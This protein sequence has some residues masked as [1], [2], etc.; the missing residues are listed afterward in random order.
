MKVNKK[1]IRRF[2][3][4][5]D[6]RPLLV[7]GFVLLANLLYVTNFFN[8][9]PM[10]LRSGLIN[11]LK[12]GISQGQYTIDPSDGFYAQALGHRAAVDA[13]RGNVP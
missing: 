3:K 12:P 11:Y 10:N 13:A 2:L 9:N 5:H 8:A 4:R 6:L 1:T 7:V